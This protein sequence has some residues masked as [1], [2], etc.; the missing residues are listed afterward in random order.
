MMSD[1]IWFKVYSLLSDY[2]ISKVKVIHETP[3]IIT[4]VEEGNE[5]RVY[6]ESYGGYERFYSTKEIAI[7]KTYERLNK[8][9]KAAEKQLA[10]AMK[11]KGD[12]FTKFGK[13]ELSN[14]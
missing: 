2:E 6:K 13:G 7:Q 3:K 8:E 14:E 5:R 12:F 4:I 1:K 11:K 10:H 9:I